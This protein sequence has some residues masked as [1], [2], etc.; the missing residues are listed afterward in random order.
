MAPTDVGRGMDI[1]VKTIT[2]Y[3]TTLVLGLAFI[4]TIGATGCAVRYYDADHRDYHRWDP[5]EI[6]PTALIGTRRTR[7]NLTATM[8]GWM[9]VSNAITGTGATAIRMRARVGIVMTAIA[10]IE[11]G[12]SY[13]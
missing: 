9:A 8:G 13:S 5:D 1:D 7:A 2:H 6:A 3:M 10:T 4:T 12:A 11:T